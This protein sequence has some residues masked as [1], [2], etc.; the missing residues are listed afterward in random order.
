MSACIGCNACTIACQAE[1][2]IPV[3]GKI[4]VNKHRE[5]HWI[6]V[7][8]YFVNSPGYE[9]DPTLDPALSMCYQPVACVH[10]ENA[11][12]ETVCP[13]NATVHG[14]EGLNYMTY[15]RCIGTRYC[16]NNCP[17]KVRRFNFFDFGVAKFNGDFIGKENAPLGG[18]KNVNLIP[19][20]LRERLDEI[21][22]MGMNP[23]VT[24]RSRGV[25]EKCSYCV[26]RIN[27]ARM[28]VKLA[29]LPG[30]PDGFF[31]T[32]CAQ[33]CP[34]D[35]IV[36]GDIL[37]L[38]TKYTDE[39]GERVGSRVRALKDNGRS[40]LLLGFLDTR[41]R[42]THMVSVRNPNPAIRKP[43]SELK[44]LHAEEEHAMTGD[45]SGDGPMGHEDEGYKMSL[46]V[47]TGGGGRA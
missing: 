19:P 44:D 27:E 28:E 40:Y 16:A 29:N 7:D 39:R 17:Y 37:D 25:M 46:T 45:G 42:T 32:A 9:G 5:M 20:R 18:P 43:I 24:V 38:H 31:Q 1:N 22:K 2:N 36:F 14:P 6:R 10:C 3:V 41:P 34:T 35:A 13:V 23:N 33:A 8:R 26:Q 12:C 4:E 15:N 21:T 11:P 47:L 30:I